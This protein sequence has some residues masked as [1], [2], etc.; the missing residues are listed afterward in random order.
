M[1][2]KEIV[3]AKCDL[4]IALEKVTIQRNNVKQEIPEKLFPSII[5]HTRI[6]TEELRFEQNSKFNDK[7]Y[8][9]S[10]EQDQPLFNVK[11]TV[12][13][14]NLLKTPPKYI[15]ETLSLGPKNAV[16]EKFNPNEVLMELDNVL[17]FCRKKECDESLITDINNVKTC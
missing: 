9:L 4:E 8:R 2:R 10:L 17:E 11:N 3:K 13:C 6:D 14:F 1:L 7:L 16:L 5:V 12:F 15:M